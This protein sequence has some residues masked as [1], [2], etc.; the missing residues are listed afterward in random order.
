M[1][2][3]KR[4]L[5][6]VRPYWFYVAASVVSMALVGLLD[7]F[8][9]LLIGPVF[10][11]VLN[12]SEQSRELHLLPTTN[13]TLKLNWFV[14]GHF[15]NVWTMVAF[16]L[17]TATVLKGIFDY[18]GTY[19]VNYAGF[20]MITDLRDDLYND[21]LRSS[22]AFF[23]RHTTGT[24]LSTIVNDIERVQFAMSSVLAEFLQQF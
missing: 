5:H 13:W 24:L 19:L 14:P 1:H 6:Y 3:L 22:A 10:D 21:I 23:T 16:A 11:Y 4:L 20:G 8:R 18:I 15:H 2:Q 17:V 9:L 12:P 7:A